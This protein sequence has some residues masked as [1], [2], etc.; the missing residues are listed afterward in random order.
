[1]MDGGKTY[2][3]RQKTP[4]MIKRSKLAPIRELLCDD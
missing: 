3:L 4:M 2:D 1:M